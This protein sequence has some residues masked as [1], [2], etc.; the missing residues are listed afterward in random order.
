MI[1]K[2][3][4]PVMTKIS[5]PL[6]KTPCIDPKRKPLLTLSKLSFS[7]PSNSPSHTLKT[8]FFIPSNGSL[9]HSKLSLL[10]SSNSPSHS[11]KKLLPDFF[12]KTTPFSLKNSLHRSKTATSS[13]TLKVLS[14][15]PFKQSLS[16]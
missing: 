2:I 12:K 9:T 4:S 8:L 10:I 3:N 14:L 13:H 7:I 5:S 1:K 6:K 11:K 16:L 15:D